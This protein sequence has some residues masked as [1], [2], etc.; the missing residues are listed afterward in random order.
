[1]IYTLIIRTY[2]SIYEYII[3]ILFDVKQSIVDNNILL[4]IKKID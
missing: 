4:Y 2:T 1:M 3:D